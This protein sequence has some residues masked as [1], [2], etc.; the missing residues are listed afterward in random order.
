MWTSPPPPS[1]T[2][3]MTISPPLNTRTLRTISP[4]SWG[5]LLRGRWTASTWTATT[6]NRFWRR[7][8]RQETLCSPSPSGTKLRTFSP[9]RCARRDRTCCFKCAPPTLR[10]SSACPC[11]GCSTWKTLWPQ[12]PSARGWIFQCGTSMP[13]WLGLGCPGGWRCT[14][15]PIKRSPPSSISPTTAW[16]LKIC[17]ALP[18]RST[19]AAGWLPS[20]AAWGTRLWTA[21]RPWGKQQAGMLTYLSSPRTT[22]GRRTPCPS[23]RRLP[24][25]WPPREG[26]TPSTS[27]GA[28]PSARP[29]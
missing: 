7:L 13:V 16:A 14:P 3:A 6:P 4:Q 1:S 12:S 22:A 27:T 24:P 21:G 9:P 8:R 11:Q 20:L 17:A 10:G 19:P 25:M 15:A 2:S 5:S 26:S 29:F 23:A 18:R 28:R